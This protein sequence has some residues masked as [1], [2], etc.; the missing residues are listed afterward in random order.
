MKN[1]SIDK[2]AENINRQKKVQIVNGL[3]GKYFFL[4]NGQM[5]NNIIIKNVKRVKANC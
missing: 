5:Q 3:L 2:Q 4:V 1:I